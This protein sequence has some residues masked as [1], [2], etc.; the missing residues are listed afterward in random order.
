MGWC[1][2]HT[3]PGLVDVDPADAAAP[4]LAPRMRG[5]LAGAVDV[6]ADVAR[7]DSDATAGSFASRKLRSFAKRRAT[8]TSID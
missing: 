5:Q 7:G 2:L 3:L 1:V 4:D 8:M 6:A